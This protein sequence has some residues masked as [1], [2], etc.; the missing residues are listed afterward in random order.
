MKNNTEKKTIARAINVVS[1]SESDRNKST[2]NP[3]KITPNQ[4]ETLL[5]PLVSNAAISRFQPTSRKRAR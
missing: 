1:V 2:N 4:I 3:A 5:R